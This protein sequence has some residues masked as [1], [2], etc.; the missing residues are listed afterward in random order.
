MFR[1][2]PGACQASR[3]SVAVAAQLS[4]ECYGMLVCLLYFTTGLLLPMRWVA[5]TRGIIRWPAT[6]RICRRRRAQMQPGVQRRL[7][8]LQHG[9]RRRRGRRR[10]RAR[11]LWLLRRR[12]W[13][14]TTTTASRSPMR[15]PSGAKTKMRKE[16]GDRK[17]LGG[18][19]QVLAGCL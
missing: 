18:N 19:T 16:A 14:M 10:G 4:D 15:R 7:R 13:I 1:G 9:L 11:Q 6:R 5:H 3:S 17:M 2:Q 12:H 8:L